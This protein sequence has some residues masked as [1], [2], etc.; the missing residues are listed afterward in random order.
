MRIK[1]D[2]L[3]ATCYENDNVT[4]AKSE[5][6]KE[7]ELTGAFGDGELGDGDCDSGGTGRDGTG[8]G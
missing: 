7:S 4:S 1:I 8:G 5:K 3:S 6:R 2:R